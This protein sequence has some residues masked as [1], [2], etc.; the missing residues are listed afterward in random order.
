MYKP[1]IRY[2]ETICISLQFADNNY[3]SFN[4]KQSTFPTIEFSSSCN[5]P[6]GDHNNTSTEQTCNT[7]C[8]ACYHR[9]VMECR[10]ERSGSHTSST[11]SESTIP[12]RVPQLVR[13]RWRPHTYWFRCSVHARAKSASSNRGLLD[14]GW[15]ST[16]RRRSPKEQLGPLGCPTTASGPGRP[17]SATATPAI[18]CGH[19]NFCKQTFFLPT[20]CVL[21]VVSQCF[22]CTKVASIQVE[23]VLQIK[24]LL[25]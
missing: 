18:S 5:C 1:V 19:A 25:R 23:L 8:Y 7:F 9:Q 24:L 12:A 13:W 16:R 14:T 11:V 15:V 21:T 20:N 2:N 10:N 17:A 22:R 3:N 4:S 6:S